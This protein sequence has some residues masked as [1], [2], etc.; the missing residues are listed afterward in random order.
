VIEQR[1]NELLPGYA[2][3]GSDQRLTDF[4]IRLL[5]GRSVMGMA[6]TH[7]FENM[8]D[9]LFLSISIINWVYF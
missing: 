3:R 2:S 1:N 4:D 6:A 9:S 5:M 7:L 8:S